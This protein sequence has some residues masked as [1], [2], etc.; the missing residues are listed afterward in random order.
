MS[1]SAGACVNTNVI[2]W[3]GLWPRRNTGFTKDSKRI[4]RGSSRIERSARGGGESMSRSA[5]GVRGMVG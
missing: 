1:D 4:Q 3:A 2:G 5:S